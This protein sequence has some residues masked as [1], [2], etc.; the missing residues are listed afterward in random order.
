MRQQQDAFHPSRSGSLVKF[1]L[2][3]VPPRRLVLLPNFLG[4]AKLRPAW[5]V[6]WIGA[7][8]ECL[9]AILTLAPCQHECRARPCMSAQPNWEQHELCRRVAESILLCASGK[10]TLGALTE[11]T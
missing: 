2:G 8:D 11:A 3:F 6:N 5:A 10:T 4:L 9:K 1:N 7:L